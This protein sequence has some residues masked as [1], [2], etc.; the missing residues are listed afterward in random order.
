MTPLLA[1][2]FLLGPPI[3]LGS[4]FDAEALAG[5]PSSREPW[6][7][8]RTAEPTITADR[9]ESGGLF[10]G[11]PALFGIHGSS[12]TDTA[13]RL[14]GVDITDPDRGGTPMITVPTEALETIT[15]AT[16]L[17][18]PSARGSGARV[19]LTA[20]RPGESWRGSLALHATPSSLAGSGDGVAPPIASL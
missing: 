12:W 19:A 4:L 1:L 11:A 8:L 2:A 3:E 7:L 10:S 16:A 6:S 5:L 15:L 13:W 17:T 18:T 9:I 14:D 20:R